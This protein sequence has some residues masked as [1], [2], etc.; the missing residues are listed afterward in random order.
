MLSD[1][2]TFG[3]K[4]DWEFNARWNYGSGFPFT[5]TQGF[6]SYL[7]F[8]QGINVNYN[9]ANGNLGIL[10]GDLNEGRLPYYHRLDLSL[11]KT[12]VLGKIQ[13]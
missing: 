2:Y 5:Q 9:T 13:H 1:H 10:Y 3:K 6:Y 7:N 12:F 4:L 8:Q 11:K